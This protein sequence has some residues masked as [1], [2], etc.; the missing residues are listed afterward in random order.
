MSLATSNLFAALDPKAK[1]K[2]K[3]SKGTSE[4]KKKKAASEAPK[5]STQDLEKAIFGAPQL[6]ISNWA[7]ADSDE[8]EDDAFGGGPAED[9]WNKV[10]VVSL[11]CCS[12][13]SDMLLNSTMS[14]FHRKHR[15]TSH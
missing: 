14:S 5:V 7:D 11:R 10:G 9:G 4:D 8:D 6:G 2:S 13:V 3:S 12:A 1:T 15:R